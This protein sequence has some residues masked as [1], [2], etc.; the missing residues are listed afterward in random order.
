[1]RTHDAPMLAPE[2]IGPTQSMTP[3]GF[4][5]CRDVPIARTGVMVYGEGEVPVEPGSDGVI[6]VTRPEEEVFSP[7]AMASFEGKPVTNTHPSELVTPDTWRDHAVGTVMNV[8]RDENRLLADLLITDGDSIKDVRNGLR[9]VSCGYDASYEQEKP[10]YAI[11][12][13]IV[14][15]HVALVP[16]GRCGPSCAISDAQSQETRPMR[17]GT[18]KDKI[19]ALFRTKDEEGV[20]ALLE[21]MEEPKGD[22]HIHMA[23]GKDNEEEEGEG[24]GEW[25]IKQLVEAVKELQADRIVRDSKNKDDF[26]GLVEELV[27]KGYSKEYATKIAGKVAAEKGDDAA[28]D[29]SEEEKKKREKEAGEKANREENK[30]DPDRESYSGDAL[31]VLKSRAEILS[32]GIR[33]SFPTGDAASKGY[34]KGACDCK[35]QALK[36]AYASDEGRTAVD[37]ILAGRS[38][39]SLSPE[40]LDAVFMGASALMGARNNQSTSFKR[41]TKDFGIQSKVSDINQANRDFWA[42]RTSR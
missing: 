21:E 41:T 10:G 9:E 39:D 23:A 36:A 15:N 22:L 14:G 38:L 16:K 25:G 33:L 42:N 11:Q 1:M 3:E 32:P 37:A 28:K 18:F 17:K 12:R 5:L 27:K 20:K 34:K 26:N 4:L 13:D 24:E 29:E 19:L 8:R 2:Q 7:T 35:R 30:E 40:T 6:Y 31:T